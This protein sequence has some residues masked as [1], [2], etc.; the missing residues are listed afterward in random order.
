MQQPSFKHSFLLQYILIL[1]SETNTAEC[2]ANKSFTNLFLPSGSAAL[3]G[4]VVEE[5]F[6]GPALFLAATLNSYE[7][8]VVRLRT[9]K[10]RS[11]ISSVDGRTQLPDPSTQYS[12][13]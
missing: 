13:M 2:I 11:G 10:S 1:A 12:T 6:P 8:P 3:I 4:F 9:V 7:T 5:N